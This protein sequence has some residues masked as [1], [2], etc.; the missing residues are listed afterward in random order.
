MNKSW[1]FF[2]HLFDFSVSERCRKVD[3]KIDEGC[4]SRV[5]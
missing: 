2:V 5:L 4:G 3:Y 1:D